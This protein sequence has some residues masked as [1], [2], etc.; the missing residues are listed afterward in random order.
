MDLYF[1]QCQMF[2]AFTTVFWTFGLKASILNYLDVS[3]S[4]L[5][6]SVDLIVH[7]SGCPAVVGGDPDEHDTLCLL[8]SHTFFSRIK[9]QESLQPLLSLSLHLDF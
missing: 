9:I 2:L 1:F 5:V 8:S 4:A 7:I 3:R 6:S